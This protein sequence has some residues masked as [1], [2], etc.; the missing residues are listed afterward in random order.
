[1]YNYPGRMP[2]GCGGYYPGRGNGYGSYDYGRER[3]R[4]HSST[5]LELMATIR[6]RQQTQQPR[7]F[8]RS[9]RWGSSAY[10]GGHR[11]RPMQYGFGSQRNS[12]FGQMRSNPY[13][14]AAMRRPT[15]APFSSLPQ[16]N[17]FRSPYASQHRPTYPRFNAPLLSRGYPPPRPFFPQR[18]RHRQQED[19]DDDDPFADDDDDW[20]DSD[21]DATYD[22]DTRGSEEDD[23]YYDDYSTSRSSY[24]PYRG[25]SRRYEDYDE[26]DYNDDMESRQYYGSGSYGRRSS[27]RSYYAW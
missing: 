14:M 10:G 24:N 15:S 9:H 22:F 4:H 19:D 8:G 7:H 1:M 2:G 16:R 27:A 18:R 12:M 21:A 17:P 26:D 13:F 25:F 11:P 23:D 3:Q 20:G 5:A 6:A